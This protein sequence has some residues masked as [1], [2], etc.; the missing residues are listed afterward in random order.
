M[1]FVEGG[2]FKH[3]PKLS[4]CHAHVDCLQLIISLTHLDRHALVCTVLLVW[5]CIS[6]LHF[7]YFDQYSIFRDLFECHKIHQIR[8]RRSRES[9]SVDFPSAWAH[10][11][12]VYAQ[13]LFTPLS[14][15]SLLF[16]YEKPLP[17]YLIYLI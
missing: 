9:P 14:K 15:G 8:I 3:L 12:W 1:K 17:F 7:A 10:W 6:I 4:P 13:L 5:L 16:Q 11:K 2:S